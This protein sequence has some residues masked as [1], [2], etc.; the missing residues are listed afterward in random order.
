MLSKVRARAAGAAWGGRNGRIA[1]ADPRE[2]ERRTDGAEQRACTDGP[3]GGY[4]N[5]MI[6]VDGIP[7]NVGPTY[8]DAEGWLGAAEVVTMTLNEFRRQASKRGKES[9]LS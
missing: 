3:S 5:G 1:E 7:I 2:H 6:E 9:K 4:D 8:S